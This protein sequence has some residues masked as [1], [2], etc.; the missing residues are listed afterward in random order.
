MNND[1]WY[2]MHEWG[3]EEYASTA[4]RT[5]LNEVVPA[6]D[7]LSNTLTEAHRS[8]TQILDQFYTNKASLTAILYNIL[9]NYVN[10]NQSVNEDGTV[11]TTDID[12][13]IARL[14]E[15]SDELVPP[16]ITSVT[17]DPSRPVHSFE[18]FY[19]STTI[20]WNATHPAGI[21]ENSIDVREF[22]SNTDI[23]V[24]YNEYLSIGERT[25]HK[26]YPY[27][28]THPRSSNQTQSTIESSNTRTIN[29]GVRVRG[30]AGNTAIRRAT[31]DVDVGP[32]GQTTNKGTDVLP[33]T[34]LRP[35]KPI[36]YL[37]AFY[38]KT[39]S[40]MFV[41]ISGDNPYGFELQDVDTYWTSDPST[42]RLQILAHDS[43]TGIS[44]YE[45][46]VGSSKGATDIIEW[47]ELQ[48]ER[49]FYAWI[50]ASGIIGNTRF[51]NMVEGDPYYVSIRVT[52]GVGA[53]SDPYESP[54]A[55]KYDG[56]PPTDPGVAYVASTF[57]MPLYLYGYST[58][59]DPVLETIPSLNI[60]SSERA[61]WFDSATPTVNAYWSESTD[62][63]SRL[64]RYEYIITDSVAA[65]IEEFTPT[66]IRRT[67]NL[68][69]EYFGPMLPDFD[70]EIYIHVRALNH[71]QMSSEIY[72]IGPL[73]PK[74]TTGPIVGRIQALIGYDRI[75]MYLTELPYDPETDLLGI[76]Y[77]IGT[78]PGATD[79]R[80]WPSNN[81]VDFEWNLNKNLA[82]YSIYKQPNP[83][84]RHFEI[85]MN[86]LPVG[87]T[88]YISYRSV[89]GQGMKSAVRST[90]PINLDESGPLSPTLSL[91]YNGTD[92][93]LNINL[94][95]IEDPQSG[96]QKVEYSIQYPYYWMTKQS[97]TDMHTHTGIKHGS[98]SLAQ[99][100]DFASGEID[101]PTNL[102]VK[103]R[104]TNG[105]GLQ[106]TVSKSVSYGD[107]YYVFKYKE[108]IY[109]FPNF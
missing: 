53:V 93:V 57:Y 7:Q 25:S 3:L 56:T 78:S 2:N 60:S 103:I 108:P 37:E 102:S 87:P 99:D 95:G 69:A 26:I 92:N 41:P 65:S 20:D 58:P 51:L 30:Y 90:G 9:D 35:D 23:S 46:A 63:E 67:S 36:L 52:N 73:K 61:S 97:W 59:V 14:N 33:T 19:N 76:Q 83:P 75:G 91:R 38:K 62:A 43:Q 47:T 70:T 4:S 29:F 6:H 80:G 98:F 8:F 94:S 18:R 101:T 96:I 81:N 86:K 42:I 32:G 31:F 89:N 79:I 40:S 88:F 104:I 15:V 64:M 71:A 105:A 16:Q 77:A 13:Y 34:Q 68:T 84:D 21:I 106:R 50:P 24:G 85:L 107:I 22:D 39:T 55:I 45:Y 5:V 72:S 109:Q 44:T 17:V 12:Q 100:V 48:G 10:W 74:D 54:A 1:F 28:R 27:K 82:L 66:A 49:D 11:S